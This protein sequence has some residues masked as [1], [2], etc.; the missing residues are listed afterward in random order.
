[1]LAFFRS[2]GPSALDGARMA[3]SLGLT[4][5]G[6]LIQSH[7]DGASYALFPGLWGAPLKSPVP[8]ILP[9]GDK[10]LFTGWFDNLHEI[11][12]RLGVPP[13]DAALVYG[14]AVRRWGDEADLHVV[15]CYCAVID[16]PD[17]G[18]VRL[19]RSALTAP[20]LHYHRSARGIAAASTPR[21]LIALGLPARLNEE[22]LAMHLHAA[23]FDAPGGWYDGIEALQ[24][25]VVVTATRE[26]ERRAKPYDPTALSELRLPRDEDY[27][28]AAE[29]LMAEGIAR[30]VAGFNRPGTL[31]SGGLD[32][33][34]V[35]SHLLDRLPPDQTLPAFTWVHEAGSQVADSPS[36]FADERSRVE[37]FAAMHP[38]VVPH[39]IDNAGRGFEDGLLDLFL[40]AG[41]TATAIGLLFP[42]HGAFAA[43]RSAGCDLII[44]AGYGNVTFSG[45]GRRAYTEFFRPG[46]LRQLWQALA[47]RPGDQRAMWRRFL[48]LTLLRQMAD[49]V[50][51][52]VSRWRGV[53]VPDPHR[54][55]GA[56]S[57]D[58]PGKAQLEAAARR[59]DPAMARPFYRSRRE[60]VAAM[61]SD[62]DADGSDL[63][64]ALQ[65]RHAIA[66][67]DVTRY[68]PFLEF[69]W[70]LPVDQM[71]RDG[72]GRF[73]ARRMGQGRLPES[74]RTE[75]RYGLQHGDWHL[76]IGR[77]REA[78]LAEL[79]TLHG[80]PQV[81][82][83]VDTA[84]L[85]QMLEEFPADD[86]VEREVVLQYQIALPNGLAAARLIRYVSG[87]NC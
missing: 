86:Q 41:T 4:E 77:R 48:S 75:I 17:S 7:R 51:Q 38:R 30:T 84:R 65:Q 61:A 73:L 71:M 57:P 29:S 39:F 46:K 53:T 68:R 72:Q 60:E 63:M 11:A 78:L 87:T 13:Q 74:L 14:H 69:C 52:A 32:S 1:M 79:R 15:G 22:R 2:W 44:G 80:D 40:L 45:E 47:A 26:G 43:A 83:M 35:A 34:I 20:P 36:H 66:Y 81:R 5:P 54:I 9:G 62:M 56:L 16:R 24:P 82:R 85:I 58:W 59:A 70:R 76:R 50:W 12:T 27:V 23:A 6:R 10:V 67:R 37:S 64:Q 55:A 18:E 49:P 8:A 21:A 42:Y 3:A 28:E 25:G 19:S 33:T 31:L